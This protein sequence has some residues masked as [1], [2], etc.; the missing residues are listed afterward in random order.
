MINLLSH[1]ENELRIL[2]QTTPDAVVL[3]FEPQIIELCKA[4]EDLGQSA[5]SAIDVA[6]AIT[7]T[8]EKLFLFKSIAPI[9]GD[10]SEWSLVMLFY[11]E[12]LYQNVRESRIFRYG[13]T[14]RPYFIEA[15]IFK[16]ENGNTS[17]GSAQLS[18]KTIGSAQ[19][20][21]SFP[22]TPKTFYIDVKSYRWKDID[23]KIPDENGDWWT[24][25]IKDE[26]QL[27]EVFQYYDIYN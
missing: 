23:G 15:I 14:E 24:Y 3:Q 13:E 20:I 11:D 2:K 25:E 6:K 18:E 26:S 27:D 4:F 8:I 19:Y 5:G 7:K 1:A 12:R 17:T 16:D 10:E 21:K 22:F 9:T